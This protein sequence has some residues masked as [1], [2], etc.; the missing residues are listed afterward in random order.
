[1]D[2]K[3]GRVEVG[4]DWEIGIDI[5]TRPGIKWASHVVKWAQW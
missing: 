1:M 3:V 2:T 4:M 5:Y